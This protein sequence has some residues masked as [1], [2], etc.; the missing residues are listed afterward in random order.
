MTRSF[1]VTGNYSWHLQQT[2]LLLISCLR[3]GNAQS[4]HIS[5]LVSVYMCHSNK[6]SKFTTTDGLTVITQLVLKVYDNW[7]FNCHYPISSCSLLSPRGSRHKDLS[8]WKSCA[9]STGTSHLSFVC[10]TV[11]VIGC[12]FD[13]QIPAQVI[14]QTGTRNRRRCISMTDCQVPRRGVWSSSWIACLHGMWQHQCLLWIG[15]DHSSQSC[16]EM[17]VAWHEATSVSAC[18]YSQASPYVWGVYI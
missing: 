7:W 6:C 12:S 1:F 4:M 13:R 11:L 14:W 9:A 8:S 16:Q 5:L 2:K 3:N 10:Q 15:K 17:H 18:G